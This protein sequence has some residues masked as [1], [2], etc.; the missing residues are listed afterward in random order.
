VDLGLKGR[1]ALVT[2]ASRGI[3]RAIATLFAQEGCNL[4]LAARDGAALKTMAD[5]LKVKFG[6]GVVPHAFDISAPGSAEKLA[7]ECGALDILVNNAGSIPRG[8]IHVIDEKTWREVW[9][10]KVFGYINLTRAVLA[11][12]E[13]R[14]KGVIVNVIGLGGERP[15]YG[16]IAGSAG[17]AALMAFSRGLGAMAFDKGVRVVGLNPGMIATD[18]MKTLLQS[19]AKDTLGDADRWQELLKEVGLPAGRPGEPE[20]IANVVVFLASDRASYVSGTVVTV[21]GGMAHRET[22]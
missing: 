6:V 9:E 13:K 1:S 2:G 20:E 4:H 21:D 8:N 19:Q 18:R 7:E 12:M 10:L 17:N 5:E 16:Y 14:G 11:P 15:I 3:G 22:H